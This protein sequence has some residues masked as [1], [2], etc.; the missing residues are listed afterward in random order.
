MQSFESIIVQSLELLIIYK[1]IN[2]SE[3][4][5]LFFMCVLFKILY[6]SW[7]YLHG[8]SK[9]FLVKDIQQFAGPKCLETVACKPFSWI[10]LLISLLTSYQFSSDYCPWMYC[11]TFCSLWNSISLR[12][13]LMVFSNIRHLFWSSWCSINLKNLM[14]SAKSEKAFPTSFSRSLIPILNNAHISWH[15]PLFCF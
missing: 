13:T 11:F 5:V 9:I 7:I 3:I 2:I 4:H 14:S 15:F 12:F 6:R 8:F 10:P 1:V